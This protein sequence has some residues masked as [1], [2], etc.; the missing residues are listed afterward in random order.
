MKLKFAIPTILVSLLSAQ[1]AFANAYHDKPNKGVTHKQQVKAK[2]SP[3]VVVK[4]NKK[5]TLPAATVVKYNGN[6]FNVVDGIF[7]M[8]KNAKYIMTPPPQ[9]LNIKVLPKNAKLVSY[10]K[11]NYYQ[12][13][14][15]Y[16]VKTHNGYQVVKAPA[17]KAARI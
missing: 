6:K 9:G 1:M 11:Q 15:V 2:V 14:N 13:K 17:K 10:N 12:Y 7:Y 16:Y 4:V 3:N 8:I 5:H